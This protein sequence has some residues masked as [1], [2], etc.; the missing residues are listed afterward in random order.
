MLF[1]IVKHKENIGFSKA[2]NQLIHWSKSEYVLCLNQDI[3]LEPDFL[4]K[5]IGFMEKSPDC[6]SA[7]GKLLRLQDDQKTKYIDS[8][9]LKISKGGIQYRFSNLTTPCF[10]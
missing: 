5:M 3:I 10:V 4:E 6:G 8:V 1:K 7:T 2:Y 9:G